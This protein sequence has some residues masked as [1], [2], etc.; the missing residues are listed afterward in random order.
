MLEFGEAGVFTKAV[1]KAHTNYQ[2]D[3]FFASVL[4]KM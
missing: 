2:T 1:E 4:G 3:G